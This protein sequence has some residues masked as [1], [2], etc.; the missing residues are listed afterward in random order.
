MKGA[1][2]LAHAYARWPE[3]RS[4]RLRGIETAAGAA[5]GDRVNACEALAMLLMRESSPAHIDT[6]PWAAYIRS[7]PTGL[8]QPAVPHLLL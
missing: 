5:D 4:V 3:L 8:E 7:L 1:S 2:A 6:S